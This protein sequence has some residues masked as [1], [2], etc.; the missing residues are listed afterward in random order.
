MGKGG[1]EK[2]KGEAPLRYN[3]HDTDDTNQFMMEARKK[4]DAAAKPPPPPPRPSRASRKA[5]KRVEAFKAKMAKQEERK[6][7][8]A[9]LQDKMLRPDETELYHSSSALGRSGKETAKQHL[10]R[11]MLEQKAGIAVTEPGRKGLVQEIE[12]NE[13]DF[14]ERMAPSSDEEGTESAGGGVAPAAVPAATEAV[15]VVEEEESEE[16][17]LVRAAKKERRD[18]KKNFFEKNRGETTYDEGMDEERDEGWMKKQQERIQ[19]WK[20][21]HPTVAASARSDDDD[22][23]D[24][25]VQGPFEEAQFAEGEVDST[26]PSANLAGFG[27]GF[28]QLAVPKGVVFEKKERVED[29]DGDEEMDDEED[30]DEDDEDEEMESEAE[31]EEGDEEESEEQESEDEEEDEEEHE[32]EHD[33]EHEHEDGCSC[34][35]CGSG[36]EKGG[37]PRE[38][39]VVVVEDDDGNIIRMYEKKDGDP[40]GEEEDE[41]EENHEESKDDGDDEKE[42]K[43][44]KEETK[45]EESVSSESEEEKEEEPKKKRRRMPKIVFEESPLSTTAFVDVDRPAEVQAAR[46]SLPIAMEEHTIMEAVHANEVVI[47]CGETGCGKTTQVPQFLYEAGFGNPASDK[48]PGMIGVTQPRRVA[49]TSMAARVA[50]ELNTEVGR[51]VAYQVRYDSKVDPHRT[52]I[53]FM[54]DGILLREIQSDFA[55]TKYS[56]LVLD[57]AHERNINTDILIGL[58]SRIVPLRNRL[59]RE[60]KSIRAGE[61]PVKPLKL[62][63]MS[64][65]LRV[66]DFTNNRTMFPVAPPV[67]RVAARQYPVTVHFN[68]KTVIGDYVGEAYAKVC[69]IHTLLPPGGI[70]VFLTGQREILHL[71]RRLARR[72]PQRSAK[73]E[74]EK[75]QT[76]SAQKKGSKDGDGE[77]ETKDDKKKVEGDDEKKEEKEEDGNGNGNGNGNESVSAKMMKGDEEEESKMVQHDE[78]AEGDESGEEDDDDDDDDDDE[79]GFGEGDNEGDEEDEDDNQMFDDVYN[80]DSDD[81]EL[82]WAADEATGKLKPQ[83][84]CPGL[85]VLPL[86]SA[87]APRKQ[88][89]VFEPPPPGCRLVVVATNVAETALTIPG[90]TY[91]VDSGRVKQRRY[92]AATGLSQFTVEWTSQASA[93]QRAGRAGRTGPGHCYRLYSSA[94]FNDYFHKFSD[95]EI[96]M[97]PVESVVLQLKVMGIDKVATFPFPTP[98]DRTALTRALRL[99]RNIGALDPADRITPLGRSIARF[100]V[101]PRYAKMLV[102]AHR[103][104]CLPWMVS[105]VA[106]LTVR[107]LFAPLFAPSPEDDD[108][109]SGS[110]K[111]GDKKGDKKDAKKSTGTSTSSTGRLSAAQCREL[112]MHPDS[113]MLAA[114]KAVEA[115]RNALA[116]GQRVEQF[117]ERYRLHQ[118]SMSEALLLREQLCAILAAPLRALAPPPTPA[119]QSTLRQ[120]VLSAFIDQVARRVTQA[121]SSSATSTG[122]GGATQFP[123]SATTT[124]EHVFVHPTS[125]VSRTCPDYVAFHEIVRSTKHAYMHGVTRVSPGWLFDL[126]AALAEVGRPVASPPPHYDAATGTVRALT[127]VAFGPH[128]W[129]LPLQDLEHP[130]GRERTRLF[131]QFVLDGSVLPALG[132]FVPHLA[133]TPLALSLAKTRAAQTFVAT[134]ARAHVDSRAALLRA[135]LADPRFLLSAYLALLPASLSPDVTAI[136]PPVQ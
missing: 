47:I 67:I 114:L 123:Y 39:V 60:G 84:V 75:D 15:G 40:I 63:I 8:M 112:W 44:K 3:P 48:T 25:G 29:E 122:G 135:F 20:A 46:M 88:R 52:R 106:A 90:I 133:A 104:D 23:E 26:A 77:G 134:L 37:K 101:H 125:F 62:V 89:R 2:A 95:P 110:D 124:E 35:C 56:V 79:F 69:K 71:C 58:L 59:A 109:N 66:E 18:K 45:E 132:R 127:R 64:A 13:D 72:F 34:C 5:R 85:C 22:A 76:K 91:V 87:L 78:D 92:D 108:T 19:L 9:T 42:E 50:Y 74:S 14:E 136:W 1:K 117:C 115:C 93:D 107:E 12:V 100:P 120:I 43:E 24:E 11:L 83:K 130:P 30:D 4:K 7:L 70:L 105:I 119:Q 102:L 41:E 16:K 55:L 31:D 96:L 27:F 21:A 99:L 118:Q 54:T 53:K 32:R 61:P 97:S 126:G 80:E 82:K 33:H 73:Q 68:R 36:D 94:V 128:H 116:K 131:A 111:K 81:E 103:C 86:Y 28:G 17:R 38:R 6:R 129:P 10:H 57:E 65:T 113:D 49:A 98:P 51:E 121:P